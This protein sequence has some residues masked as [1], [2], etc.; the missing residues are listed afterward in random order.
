MEPNN[1]NVDVTVLGYVPPDYSAEF[2]RDLLSA[3]RG[4]WG[5]GFKFTDNEFSDGRI[6]VL[7]NVPPVVQWQMQTFVD[8]YLACEQNAVR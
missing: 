5:A 3:L 2:R 4:K 8:G 6:C 1:R 7:G